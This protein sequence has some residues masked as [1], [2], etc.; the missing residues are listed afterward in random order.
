M[1][2]NWLAGRLVDWMVV[3]LLGW[4]WL[5]SWLTGTSGWQ[6]VEV[7]SQAAWLAARDSPASHLTHNTHYPQLTIYRPA[8]FLAL[9]RARWLLLLGSGARLRVGT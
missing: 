6:I 7:A 1:S 4:R 2:I 5:A 8:I 9:A 3:W